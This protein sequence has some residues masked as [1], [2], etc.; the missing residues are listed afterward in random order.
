[1]TPTTRGKILRA[2]NKE[3]LYYDQHT[4]LLPPLQPGS[5]VAARSRV[6]TDWSLLGTVL[7]I[8]PNRTFAVQ[9]DRGSVLIRNRKYLVKLTN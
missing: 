3:K 9:T 2:K 5:R 8:T 7:E 4:K 6:D 1:M